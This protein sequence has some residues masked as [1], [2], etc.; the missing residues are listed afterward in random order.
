[1]APKKR[2]FCPHCKE[3]VSVRTYREHFNLY[4]SKEK[5]EWQKTESSDEEDGLVQAEARCDLF[6][7][8]PQM[9]VDEHEECDKN[10]YSET[11]KHTRSAPSKYVRTSMPCLDV[12]FPADRVYFPLYIINRREK[13]DSAQGP[14]GLFRNFWVGM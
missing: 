7:E 10:L 5:D 6:Y 11:D 9:A 14:W 13:V 1:M 3:N 8:S 4:F 2:R 12:S